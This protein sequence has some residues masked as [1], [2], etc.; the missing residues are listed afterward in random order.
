MKRRLASWTVLRL[1][2]LCR[3][4]EIA[5]G[6]VLATLMFMTFTDVCGRYLFNSPV[7]GGYELTEIGVAVIVF[8]ALPAV[9]AR[10]AHITTGLF[11]GGLRGGWA[12]FRRASIDLLSAL[13]LGVLAWRLWVIAAGM[14]ELKT[15]S[16]VLGMPLAPLAYAM[17]GASTLATASMLLRVLLPARDEAMVD[18]P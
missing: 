15:F 14:A 8:G 2:D 13:A 12:R 11:E 3:F 18:A 6:G 9:T 7:V 17:A 10:G 1:M 16:P 5:A 4:G